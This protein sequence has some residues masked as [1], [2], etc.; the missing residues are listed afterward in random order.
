MR[1]EEI[2]NSARVIHEG[3]PRSPVY[4]RDE[5][6]RW[7]ID[8]L[9]RMAFGVVSGDIVELSPDQIRIKYPGE[10]ENPEYKF[11][12]GGMAWARSVDLSEPVE[13]SINNDG[14]YEL[15]DGHH[16][17]FAA[18]LT[19]RK[20]RAEVEIKA[21]TIDFILARQAADPE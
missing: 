13:V 19:G 2:I 8:D 11:Q 4:T 16:R 12:R 1:V 6:E 3:T 9:D 20:L 15:E 21:N 18:R 7:D 5:L 17:W 14:Q 10:I